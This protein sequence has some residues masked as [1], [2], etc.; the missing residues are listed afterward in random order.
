MKKND[1]IFW[2]ED[3]FSLRP[4][5]DIARESSNPKEIMDYPVVYLLYKKS[6][7]GNIYIGETSSAISRLKT[8][9]KDEEKKSFEQFSIIF[10]SSFHKS[11]TYN[12]ETNLIQYI[13]ADNNDFQT[14]NTTQH[15]MKRTHNYYQKEIYDREI[16]GTI[17]DELRKRG[18]ANQTIEEIRNT[19]IYKLSPFTV[20]NDEQLD[21]K[22]QIINF[23][24]NN[25]D[26]E[27]GAV[28]IVQGD[29]GTG[30]SVLL[31]SVFK[32]IQ[33]SAKD[34]SSKLH[35]AQNN[36]LLVNH[37][38]MFKTYKNIAKKV[39]NLAVKNFNKPTS[40][41]NSI[42]KERLSNPEAIADIVLVDE[43]H[44]L[45]STSDNYNN[46]S[47]T[48]HLEEIMKR[49]KITIIIFDDRQVLKAKSYWDTKS[50]ETIVN[51]KPIEWVQLSQQMRMQANKETQDWIDNIVNKKISSIPK[52]EN[53][54]IKIFE[55]AQ[56][57][58]EAIKQKDRQ[59]GISR[60]ISTFDY[61]H[62][63]D[64]KDYYVE[65]DEMNLP[66]NRIYNKNTWAEV[67]ESKDE[68]GSIYTIQGFDLNYAGVILGPSITYNKINDRI[69]IDTSKYKDSEAFKGSA[70]I[71]DGNGNLIPQE[72]VKEE[73]ILNSLN[74]LLKRG[75]NGLYIYASDKDL[76][77][78]LRTL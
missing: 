76:N 78:K 61:L 10:D 69:E 5:D 77:E 34:P 13:T 36:H 7:R 74:V 54:E 58:Y 59:N 27:N 60:M 64:G 49:S 56:E 11:A 51:N 17:W 62:K 16:F 21:V 68:V 31:S 20:L 75:V 50:L 14:T 63:K 2:L 44:L 48:N 66:W 70:T 43:A 35:I 3:N 55:T 6:K 71:Y 72:K 4:I 38:E 28:L 22:E 41:I 1:S 46:F 52:D 19:D 32:S 33:D 53:Y 18:F 29:A 65:E 39:S 67:K 9:L 47:Q 57:M 30:K 37:E 12:I 40:F 15:K 26:N 8:H 42:D 45:L 73:I 24:E 25:I 23:C